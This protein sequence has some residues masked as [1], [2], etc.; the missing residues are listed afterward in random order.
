M[1]RNPIKINQRDAPC[2][3]E[4]MMCSYLN[5]EPDPSQVGD[6]VLVAM[7]EAA[8]AAR[9]MYVS[10]SILAK[11][12]SLD[13]AERQRTSLVGQTVTGAEDLAYL[14]QLYSDPRFETFRVIFTGVEQCVVA[15]VGLT[16]R[17]PASTQAFIGRDLDGY[18]NELSVVAKERGATAFYLLHN[19]PS[20]RASPSKADIELTKRFA[21]K[22]PS[23]DFKGHVVIDTNEY[24]FIDDE[25][26]FELFQANFGAPLPISYDEWIGLKFTSPK[27]VMEA[28]KRLS[29]DVHSITFIT[30]DAQHKV[31][32]VSTKP[33]S[34][35][36]KGESAW[37]LLLAKDML[38]TRGANIFAVSKNYVSLLRISQVLTDAIWIKED[39]DIKSLR[40]MGII[41]GGGLLPR[42]R[43]GRL[44]PDTCAAFSYLR[45]I[46]AT[47]V[48]Q[49]KAEA[50][51]AVA[52]FSPTRNNIQ[53]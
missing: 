43:R 18:L 40:E 17:L 19:H 21:E 4:L 29:C 11:S 16:S 50:D 24:A 45:G 51:V 41:D 42:T 37:K 1:N 33:S 15:Q 5:S 32:S 22:M 52:A 28:A 27:D 20:G 26:N 13:L 23:L 48:G 10:T 7:R 3:D 9:Q 30:T 47:S 46:P 38:R 34:I 6:S 35:F 53:R 49:R 12:M 39:G 44:S 31:K 2:F 25:G 8:E 14:A 36:D